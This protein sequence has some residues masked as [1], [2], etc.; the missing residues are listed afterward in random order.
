[1]GTWDWN[2]ET[3]ELVW[4]ERCKALFAVPPGRAVSYGT[5]LDAIHHDDRERIHRGLMA[6]LEAR[7][8]YAAEMRVPLPDGTVRWVAS[9][10]HA[11]YGADGRP[12]RMVGV[13]RDVTARKESETAL[14][15]SEQIL[16]LFIENAPAA[17]AMFDRDMRYLSVSRRWIIDYG[18]TGR[19]I[20]GLS[21]YEVFPEIPER[22]RQA[23]RRCL[24][25]ATESG[26]EDLFL[27]ADGR[28]DWVRWVI[29]P[30][31]ASCGD[32]GGL[33]MFT[34]VVTER[35]RLAE[36]LRERT[37]FLMTQNDLTPEGIALTT[38]DG[39]YVEVNRRY[40][41]I[42][43]YS[44]DELKTRTTTDMGI[45]RAA[46]KGKP[47]STASGRRAPCA[48]SRRSSAPRRGA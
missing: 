24:A 3:G 36:E 7:T 33:I 21:H 12:L 40:C 47:A 38:Q 46:R 18:L 23:H 5:F 25:G 28:T 8:D 34:E 11:F 37:R 14:A 9:T 26:D 39:R 20:I 6:A 44:A 22:W 41:E 4:S 42:T 32:V 17:I 19:D 45:C 15:R 29:L 27:R 1:M 13:V 10:G 35:K 43:G 16:R 48:A 2:V 30:W 31:Y